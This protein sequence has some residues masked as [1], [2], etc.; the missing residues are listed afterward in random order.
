MKSGFT[1][2]LL[3]LLLISFKWQLIHK[4]Q[5]RGLVPFFIN[6]L[7]KG[8]AVSSDCDVSSPLPHESKRGLKWSEKTNNWISELWCLLKLFFSL[9]KSFCLTSKHE[10]VD[11]YIFNPQRH[12]F[13]FHMGPSRA[14]KRT[15]GILNPM[16]IVRNSEPW[17]QEKGKCSFVHLL[18]A[19]WYMLLLRLECNASCL[20]I[21]YMHRNVY[22]CALA[23]QTWG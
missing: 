8:A 3:Q 15:P 16:Q 23:V 7:K 19:K 9:S 14:F 22:K 21:V 11:N 20:K 4:S 5:T 18:S 17:N 10:Y 1:D 12:Q 6:S 2:M 13:S